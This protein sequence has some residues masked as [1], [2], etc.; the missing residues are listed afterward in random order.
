MTP[1]KITDVK[2][3]KQGERFPWGEIIVFHSVGEYTIVEYYP[4]VYINCCG[5]DQ[6]NKSKTEFSCYIDGFS[7]SRGAE[8]LDSALATCIAY[9]HDGCNSQAGLYFMKMIV[10]EG[11]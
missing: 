6:L 2:A 7:I 4:W 10:K 11:K 8:S 1:K 5:T 3:L 9:K